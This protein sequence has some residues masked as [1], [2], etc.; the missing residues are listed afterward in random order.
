MVTLTLV[1]H[2]WFSISSPS[3]KRWDGR[4]N[5]TTSLQVQMPTRPRCIRSI[6]L[7]IMEKLEDA[8]RYE[9]IKGNESTFAKRTTNHWGNLTNLLSFNVLLSS[10]ELNKWSILNWHVLLSSSEES[11]VIELKPYSYGV[12]DV[13]DTTCRHNTQT[14][15]PDLCSS[16]FL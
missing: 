12:L 7:C 10:Y 13:S 4:F 5:I 14:W 9:D 3:S 2:V 11:N 1:R 6:K 16:I 8:D 15:G